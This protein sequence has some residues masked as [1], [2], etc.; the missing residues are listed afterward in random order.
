MPVRPLHPLRVYLAE[1]DLGIARNAELLGLSERTLRDVLAW[2]RR[3]VFCREI[4][5][6]VDLSSAVDDLF[7]KRARDAPT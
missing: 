6:A 2:K 4:E 5:I 1:R 7:P 3:L